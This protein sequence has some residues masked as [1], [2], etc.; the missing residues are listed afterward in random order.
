M[1]KDLPKG[2][3][4]AVAAI[5]QKSR[6]AFVAEQQAMKKPKLPGVPAPKADPAANAGAAAMAKTGIKEGAEGTVAKTPKEKDLAAHH[7]DKTKITQGDVLKARGVG[8]FNWRDTARQTSDG[9]TKTGHTM[10]KTSTGTQYTK[11]EVA[12]VEEGKVMDTMK[13]GAKIAFRA[14]TGGSDKD[15]LKNLQAKMGMKQT[16]EK[17]K[18]VKEEAEQVDEAMKTVSKHGVGTGEHHAV[19]KRDAEWNEYQVHFYKNG[20]HMGEGPVSHHDDK[21]DAQDT[22]D[23]EVK[24]MNMKKEEVEQIDELS[25]DKLQSYMRAARKDINKHMGAGD[26]PAGSKRK[27]AVDKRVAGYRKAWAK[28]DMKEEVEQTVTE[29]KVGEN[30]HVK[31]TH[32]SGDREDVYT[33]HDKKTGQKSKHG[34]HGYF[35]A[36]KEKPQDTIKKQLQK[37]NVHSAAH[38]MIVKHMTEA[39]DTPGNSYEH[40]CA[41]HVKHSKLGE[42]RTLYSQ[43]AEPDAEGNIAWYDVMFAE[44]I[45]RVKTNEL[46]ILMSESHMNHK[47]KA[48]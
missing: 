7:G 13:K 6:E 41:I 34:I 10:K 45:S 42:G 11:E 38:D 33:V 47:K 5:N 12:E 39:T 1:W 8:P 23:S 28:R 4:S 40:Q 16:G 32:T 19:V 37:Q 48:K 21:K 2:L 24:R 31:V 17:P 20:K 22:A 44:G 30:E 25:S 46:E 35:I 15:Q 14:L 9:K 27:A 18:A 29:A 43:H 26:P 36:A 3:V